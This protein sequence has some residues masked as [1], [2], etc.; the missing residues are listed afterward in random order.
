[1]EAKAFRHADFDLAL[2]MKVTF[3]SG[4]KGRTQTGGRIVAITDKAIDQ[5]YSDLRRTSGGQRNDYFALLY[6]MQEFG[7][8][9]DIAIE[10]VAFGGN[11]YG[12][13]GFHFDAEK[14]NFYL[15]QFKWSSS[16][17]QFKPSFKR[18]TD[19]GMERIFGAQKQ[20]QHQNQLLLQ[21]KSC[22]LENEAIIDRVYIHFVYTGDPVEAERSQVLEWHRTFE[23]FRSFSPVACRASRGHVVFHCR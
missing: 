22:L 16:Y 3:N 19:F 12:V 11:D 20:D 10:Q 4:P 14:R 17:E 2:H 21:I 1:V 15:F 6:L 13:D 9:R 23:A 8:E 5:A 7:I 18:L